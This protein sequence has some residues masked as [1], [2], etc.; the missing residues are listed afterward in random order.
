LLFNSAQL[1]ANKRRR[2]G[3]V[4]AGIQG[5]YPPGFGFRRNGVM[6]DK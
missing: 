2:S 4:L 1:A 3:M 5:F 6:P